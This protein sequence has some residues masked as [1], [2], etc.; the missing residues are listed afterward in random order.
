MPR[1]AVA[2]P[3]G[4]DDLWDAYDDETRGARPTNP[5]TLRKKMQKFLAEFDV[6]VTSFQ[7]LLGVNSN[8]YGKFMAGNYKDKWRAM[9]NGTYAAADY[10]FWREKKLKSLSV[11]ATL[12]ARVAGAGSS[13]I[14]ARSPLASTMNQHVGGLPNG[15]VI[16]ARD[17]CGAANA[18]ANSRGKLPD[19]SDVEI[20]GETWLTPGEVRK[21]I[22]DLNRRYKF[23]GAE[24]ARAAECAT[25]TQ[26]GASVNRF[27]GK[28]GEFGGDHMECYDPL[29]RFC[30]K[31]R[32]FEK[33][34]KSNKR[35]ALEIDHARRM[36]RLKSMPIF[37][38]V[39]AVGE[40][41]ISRSQRLKRSHHALGHGI[42][43]GLPRSPR[44][45]V[46]TATTKSVD[47]IHRIEHDAKS[48]HDS[49]RLYERSR[50]GIRARS[51]H[52]LCS[53]TSRDHCDNQRINERPRRR[54]LS[55]TRGR[56]RYC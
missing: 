36:E 37:C 35:Q 6:A 49:R 39:A 14:P 13:A 53:T 17:S 51:I 8:S 47:C 46:I 38:A 31:M 21:E 1:N 45:Y 12:R 23:S 40:E 48:V 29:A 2:R 5:T 41:T 27:L 16:P 54:A 25:G 9:D 11:G 24:L 50:G 33:R 32:I 56:G 10:F 30:E 15:A 26:P 34:P 4:Y 20:D 22:N 44:D 52:D 19:V 28:G 3:A 55:K 42:L 7:T 18:K 43:E